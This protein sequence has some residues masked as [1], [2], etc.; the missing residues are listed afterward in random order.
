MSQQEALF[1]E[2][3]LLR[4]KSILGEK[5]KGREMKN[6]LPKITADWLGRL[7]LPLVSKM[8]ILCKSN[9]IY[10]NLD[11]P[12]K[13]P[14]ADAEVKE[15]VGS[16]TKRGWVRL[17]KRKTGLYVNGRKIILHLGDGQK[18]GRA[19]T[20]YNL[21]E[22][23]ADKSVEHPNILDAL[24]EHSHLISDDLR[25][26]FNQDK[27][28]HASVAFWAVVFRYKKRENLCYVRTLI[29]HKGE[30][31]SRHLWLGSN[32]GNRSPVAVRED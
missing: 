11:V 5:G 18:N 9:A 1:G 8:Q 10:V 17:E 30:W 14:F 3:F 20:G 6:L 2:I 25:E 31:H 22:A 28:N 15:S 26:F 21:K 19:I 16:A 23:L 13:L 29:V 12:P 4:N 24:I 32:M 27:V 7:V